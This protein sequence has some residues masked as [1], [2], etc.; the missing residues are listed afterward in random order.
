MDPADYPYRVLNDDRLHALLIGPAVSGKTALGLHLARQGRKVL[1]V[2]TRQCGKLGKGSRIEWTTS[3]K[4]NMFV[5]VVVVGREVLSKPAF[6]RE[7]YEI[8]SL[9]GWETFWSTSLAYLFTPLELLDEEVS[10]LGKM[11]DQ[12]HLDKSQQNPRDSSGKSNE[13]HLG[14]EYSLYWHKTYLSL[15]I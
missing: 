1:T 12:F 8:P 6:H 11:A 5:P 4:T 7:I 3:N 14:M 2:A 9:P 10:P 15:C 13:D